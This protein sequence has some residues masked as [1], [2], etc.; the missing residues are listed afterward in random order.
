MRWR[1]H[2]VNGVLLWSCV[3]GCDGTD[4][5][6]GA[7]MNDGPDAG[8]P[9][10]Q[11]GEDLPEHSLG[12][13][14]IADADSPQLT[15][16]DLDTETIAGTLPISASTVFSGASGR[17][18][19]SHDARDA[20]LRVLDPGQW[21]LS[22]IDHFHIVKSELRSRPE[23]LQVLALS[24]LASNEGWISAVDSEGGT[25]TSFQ[26]RS[27]TAMAFTPMVQAIEPH[28]GVAVVSHAHL[29][30]SDLGAEGWGISVRNALSPHEL[31]QRFERCSE[32]RSVAATTARVLVCCREGLLAMDWQEATGTFSAAWAA[33]ASGSERPTRVRTS[34]ASD[35]VVFD[36][37]P[38]RLASLT[39]RG[40]AE[41]SF[42][43][44]ILD[45]QVR[46]QGTA[47]VVLTSDG[48]LHEV[49]VSEFAIARSLH[50]LDAYEGG[51]SRAPHFALSHAYAYV[52][53]TRLAEVL[54][55]RL[56]AWE[57]ESRLAVGGA[58][59][60]ISLAGMPSNYTDARE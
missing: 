43:A 17:Y 20:L 44:S 29:L 57:V 51:A 24:S 4:D 37:G 48:R 45:F 49:D 40:I 1:L 10:E 31:K 41:V 9:W 19:Y 46:R 42:R 30:L 34:D 7:G 6:A 36:M 25:V 50:L 13:L 39:P 59:L 3:S 15:V 28:P 32:P 21:L 18:G 8:L 5:T 33:S 60:G 55:V 16:F 26:E 27:I 52:T 23:Q 58:P 53:D 35:A 38:Y 14:L 54:A 11:G 47:V 12:R 2:L 22:H 56:A